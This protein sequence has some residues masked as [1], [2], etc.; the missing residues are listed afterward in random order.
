MLAL[1]EIVTR[2]ARNGD[3]QIAYQVRGA[4]PGLVSLMG[5]IPG[6]AM[7]E[8][9]L[10]AAYWERQAGF[11]RLVVLDERGSGRSDPLPPGQSPSVDDQ[12]DDLVA[13]LDDAGIERVFISTIHAGGGVGVAF[14]VRYP[15]RTEGLFIVNG[16]ARLIKG[17]GYPY[18]MTQD[19]Q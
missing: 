10:S 19:L 14:A 18:G 1:D 13:V 11:S 17:N 8:E 6:L 3:A 9:P 4:G 16:W 12:A 7:L 5:T 2:Y 15:E